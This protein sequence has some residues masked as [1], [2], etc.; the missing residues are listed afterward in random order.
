MSISYN[1]SD[2]NYPARSQAKFRAIYHQTTE[3][4][5][6]LYIRNL[7]VSIIE[8]Q[9]DYTCYTSIRTDIVMT[10]ILLIIIS[11]NLTLLVLLAQ[12]DNTD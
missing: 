3:N 6:D 4:K 2:P 8:Q 11:D 5:K 10:K 7:M 12:F 9:S 1:I